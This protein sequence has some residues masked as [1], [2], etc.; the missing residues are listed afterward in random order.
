MSHASF[1]FL[2]KVRIPSKRI[3]GTRHELWTSGVCEPLP[4]QQVMG[5]PGLPRAQTC[6]M[7]E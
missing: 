3:G 4:K 2:M 5:N 6:P 7:R 1:A